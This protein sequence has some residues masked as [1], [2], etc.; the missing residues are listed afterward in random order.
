MTK[1]ML[2]WRGQ[3]LYQWQDRKRFRLHAS[4]FMLHAENVR[5]AG[6]EKGSILIVVLWSLFFLSMLAVAVNAYIHPQLSLAGKLKNRVKTHYLAR[7]GVKRAI[8]EIERDT[9]D[10][11]DALNDPWS[12]NEDGFKEM[13]LGDGRFTISYQTTDDRQQTTERYGLVDEERKININKVSYTVLKNFFEIAGK[14]ASQQASDIAASIIDWRDKNDEPQENGAESGYYLTLDP[15]Y[16]CK[17]GDFEVL[18][19][20]LLVKGMSWKVFDKV[21]DKITIYGTGA[22]NINTADKVVL[23]SLGMS[24]VLVE[25]VIH[26]RKG[27]DGREA[28]EDDNIFKNVNTIVSTLINSEGLSKSE[29]AQINELIHNGLICVYSSNF[30]GRSIGKVKGS[31]KSTEIIFVVDRNKVLKYWRED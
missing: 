2:N 25:K 8:L 28:T 15:P 21:K 9:T 29:I 13:E 4:C 17:N 14:V 1:G 20:L 11:Y 5:R 24:K 27:A 30:K 12:N 18:E 23:Q 16:P 22:V 6:Y 7:A 26:F 19:E 10:S 31:Q 3:C